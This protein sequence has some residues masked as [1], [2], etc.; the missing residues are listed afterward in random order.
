M[1]AKFFMTTEEYAHK[2]KEKSH[3]FPWMPLE[4]KNTMSES[5]LIRARQ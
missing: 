3:V 2:L 4:E 1:P 5:D